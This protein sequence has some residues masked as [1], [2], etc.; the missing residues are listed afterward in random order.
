[1][2]EFGDAMG[3][4]TRDIEV[5]GVVEADAVDLEFRNII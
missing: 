5:R 4:I 2:Q 1:L 3:R